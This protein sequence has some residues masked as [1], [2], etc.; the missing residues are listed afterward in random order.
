VSY[1]TSAY[2]SAA[3]G[4]LNGDG[5]LDLVAGQWQLSETG[6]GTPPPVLTSVGFSVFLSLLDGG[7]SSPIFYDGGADGLLLA[8]ADVNDDGL[9]DVVASNLNSVSVYLS[10]GDAGLLPPVEYPTSMEVL[11]LAL[12]DINGDGFPDLVYS[13]NDV[14]YPDQFFADASHI[15]V[16]LNDGSGRFT[17]PVDVGPAMTTSY[18]YIQ[19]LVV[20]DLNRDGRADIVALGYV[21]ELFVLIGQVGGGF[22]T[23]VYNI[24]AYSNGPGPYGGLP[25]TLLPGYMGTPDI[26]VSA[27]AN[28]GTGS[29][30]YEWVLVM[31][32]NL[33]D[34]EFVDGGFLSVAGEDWSSSFDPAFITTGDFNGDCLPDL[35]LSGVSNA[36]ECGNDPNIRILY[37]AA[38]GGFEAVQIF[39][40]PGNGPCGLALLG[41]VAAPRAIAVS[42]GCGGVSVLGK[43]GGN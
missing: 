4:D 32:Q 7:L 39:A 14:P 21:P 17:S 27:Y 5:L 1:G 12:G 43:A 28:T 38:D 29:S 36:G 2:Q 6:T 9:D 40:T 26:A 37:G 19:Q 11:A 15:F 25:M 33:G 34:G 22:H 8:I 20:K 31:L 23:D 13:D 24:G 10:S 18:G 42:D 30:G 3:S 16:L 35:A 41:P